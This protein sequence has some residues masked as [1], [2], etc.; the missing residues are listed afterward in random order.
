MTSPSL[1]DDSNSPNPL[2]EGLRIRPV[3]DPAIVVIF[4]ATGD[5]AARKLLPAL[6]ALAAGNFLPPAFAVL[7][8]GR[9]DKDDNA[10]RDD[11]RKA[12]EEHGQNGDSATTEGFLSQVYYQRGN[13]DNAADFEALGKR[14]KKIAAERNIAPNVLFYLSTPPEHFEPVIRNLGHTGLNQPENGWARVVIEKPFGRDLDSAH[15]LNAVVAEHFGEEQVF[16]IDHYLGKENVQNILVFR[17]ANAIFEPIWNRRYVDNVQ[18]TVAESLGMEGR[19]DFFDKAGVARDIMQNHLLQLLCLTA[20]EPPV[21]LAGDAVRDEKVKVVRSLCRIEADDVAAQ[22]SRGQ[23]TSGDLNGKSVPGYLQEEEV[24]ADSTT[25]TYAAA[26]VFIDNWRWSGVPFYLRAGKRMPHKITEI[27]IEFRQ[28]PMHL[29]EETR[30]EEARPNALIMNIQ[31]DE[32]MAVRFYSKVPGTQMRVRPVV[33][34]FRYGSSFGVEPPDAY[35]R[36]LLDALL[37]DSTLFTRA[38]EVEEAWRFFTPILEAWEAAGKDGMH[39]YEAG[40]WGPDDA[41]RL[42]DQ[43][44]KQWRR[45]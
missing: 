36:L 28:A 43:D 12:L 24:P 30:G 34:D 23:Y 10:F 32:G 8:Y 16:R 41:Q 13:L 14:L 25:E 33:M 3:P 35:E 4:G 19:G 9:R 26:R 22:T 40:T 11:V 39:N 15:E 2:R 31:P 18:I 7:G 42:T 27:A 5:L 20:M 17:Y 38:D 37:G 21:A 6:Q 45:L 29:F 44:D 1:T